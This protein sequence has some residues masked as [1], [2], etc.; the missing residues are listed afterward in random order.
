NLQVVSIQPKVDEVRQ[1]LGAEVRIIRPLPLDAL[2]LFDAPLRERLCL[3]W[4]LALIRGAHRKPGAQ[5]NRYDD[6]AK[7]GLTHHQRNPSTVSLWGESQH[8]LT[9]EAS[10]ND[11][12]QRV[13]LLMTGGRGGGSAE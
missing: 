13:G 1:R 6:E 9:N 3:G 10:Q 7:P 12:A 2:S 11:S 4:L 8:F 5:R